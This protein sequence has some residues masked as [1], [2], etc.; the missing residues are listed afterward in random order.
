MS[1][2]RRGLYWIAMAVVSV[3]MAG[4]LVMGCGNKT[5]S[6]NGS[7]GQFTGDPNTIRLTLSPDPVSGLWPKDQGIRQEMEQAAGITVIDSSTWDEFGIFAGGHDAD[8]I[9]TASCRDDPAARRSKTGA[10]T[11]RRLRQAQ[12]STAA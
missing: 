1:R 2:S 9:S 6:D 10:T 3:L 8:V 5:T 7:S 11:D 4:F 12:T